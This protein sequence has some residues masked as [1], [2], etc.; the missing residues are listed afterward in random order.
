MHNIRSRHTGA[1]VVLA[2][3]LTVASLLW[4]QTEQDGSKTA[5]LDIPTGP[6]I[7]KVIPFFRAPD[8]HGKMQDLSSIRGPKGAMVVFFR[9]ADW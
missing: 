1:A 7:G 5:A 3:Y 2:L 6:A 8:Q 9:S 4:G